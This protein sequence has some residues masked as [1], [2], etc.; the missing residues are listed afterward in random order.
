MTMLVHVYVPV[1]YFTDNLTVHG[2]RSMTNT[3]LRWKAFEYRPNHNRN[4]GEREKYLQGR[5]LSNFEHR[6]TKLVEQKTS[7]IPKWSKINMQIKACGHLGRMSV[8]YISIYI[9]IYI[10][11][12]IYISYNI[13]IYMT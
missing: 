10:Y 8:T 1:T 13:Y 5:I 4:S 6:I 2:L 7:S 12:H 3:W 9:Y 11:I